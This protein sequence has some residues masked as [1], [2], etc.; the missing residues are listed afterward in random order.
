MTASP[1]LEQSRTQRLRA[2]LGH[3]FPHAVVFAIGPAFFAAAAVTTS[4][5]FH[6]GKH[7]RVG[8]AP[9]LIVIGVAFLL[10]ASWRLVSRQRRLDVLEAQGATLLQRAERTE[11]ALV[12]LGRSE[13]DDLR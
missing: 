2:F 6:L 10:L 5:H 4:D 12:R 11:E 7:H 8:V 1:A 9:A 13:R 3:W